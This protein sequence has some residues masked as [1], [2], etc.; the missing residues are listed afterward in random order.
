MRS[1]PPRDSYIFWTPPSLNSRRPLR[2][3]SYRRFA[4]AATSRLPAHPPH[5]ASE[6]V[7]RTTGAAGTSL[8]Y[9]EVYEK[10]FDGKDWLPY[11]PEASFAT[12]VLVPS[13]KTLEGF[14]VVT[15]FTRSSPECSPLSCNGI[16]GEIRTNEHCLMVSFENA[17]EKVSVGA[18]NQSEP[19][20]YRIFAVYSVP[21][22]DPAPENWTI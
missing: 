14:D 3:S 4:L 11:Q 17:Y 15:F 13:E 8:F 2:I 22:A 5:A 16:A 18:F 19:R 10:E 7:L 20:P 21:W 12:N 6:F 9:Y 1:T